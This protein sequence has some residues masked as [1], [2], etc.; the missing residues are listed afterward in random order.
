MEKNS[1]ARENQAGDKSRA[2]REE[3]EAA[4][5][6]RFWAGLFKSILLPVLRRFLRSLFK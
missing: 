3:K 5:S 2:R 1:A 6:R 4:R